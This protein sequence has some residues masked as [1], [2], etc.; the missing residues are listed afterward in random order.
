MQERPKLIY[1]P[2]EVQQY[3]IDLEN[4]LENLQTFC[5]RRPDYKNTF[6]LDPTR[7]KFVEDFTEMSVAEKAIFNLEYHNE[8]EEVSF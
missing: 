1:L 7:I 6:Q 3:V 5:A 2:R 8:D 4:K